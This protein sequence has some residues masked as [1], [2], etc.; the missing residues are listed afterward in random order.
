VASDS[1]EESTFNTGQAVYNDTRGVVEKKHQNIT[2]GDENTLGRRPVEVTGIT[3]AQNSSDFSEKSNVKI[4]AGRFHQNFLR[5]FCR[6]CR[7][8]Q[9]SKI[10]NFH[11][12]DFLQ[13]A[14]EWQ[15]KN[16]ASQETNS[17]I[18]ERSPN[19]SDAFLAVYTRI[20]A[21]TLLNKEP[22]PEEMEVHRLYIYLTDDDISMCCIRDINYEIIAAEL[23]VKG[24]SAG[25]IREGLALD[26][27]PVNINNDRHFQAI[28]Q[29]LKSPSRALSFW[30]SSNKVADEGKYREHPSTRC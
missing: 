17:I 9:N 8:P 7:S 16:N 30:S 22:E 10:Q 11:E 27:A 24:S 13:R 15:L 29:S 18:G 5:F 1:D 4:V 2:G 23:K 14:I 25:F 21:I 19:T 6:R 28:C 3:P 20:N 12:G 26:L